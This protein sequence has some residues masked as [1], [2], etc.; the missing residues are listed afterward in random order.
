M[1]SKI[2]LSEVVSHGILKLLHDPGAE[3]K[4]LIDMAKP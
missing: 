4:I 2:A 3:V 1:T